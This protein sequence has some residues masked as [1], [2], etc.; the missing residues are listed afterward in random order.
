MVP[1]Y[2]INGGTAKFYKWINQ[3]ISTMANFLSWHETILLY[4]DYCKIGNH[5]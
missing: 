5:G 4:P 2:Q 1:V 3:G